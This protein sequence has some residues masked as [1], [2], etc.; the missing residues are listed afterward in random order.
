MIEIVVPVYGMKIDRK[1]FERFED[2][3]KAAP[4]VRERY[5]RGDEIGEAQ[6]LELVIARN[7]P[8]RGE[9]A[10]Q[11]AV[12]CHA[13]LPDGKHLQRVCRVIP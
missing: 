8:H 3:V 7:P 11:P 2:K 9:H 1:F 13:A 12:K 5:Q 10:E 6:P 4:E